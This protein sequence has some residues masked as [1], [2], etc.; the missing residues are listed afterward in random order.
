MMTGSKAVTAR[1]ITA[2][3][4]GLMATAIQKVI[5]AISIV[6]MEGGFKPSCGS[7]CRSAIL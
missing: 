5:Q 7:V 4:F 3:V 1:V 2:P 6:V